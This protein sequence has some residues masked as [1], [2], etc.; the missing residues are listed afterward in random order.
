MISQMAPAI[1]WASF[2]CFFR[3][4]CTSDVVREM[5]IAAI[6]KTPSHNRIFQKSLNSSP[7]RV[8]I[9]VP[10]T[11]AKNV[12]KANPVATGNR[13]NALEI[14]LGYFL[15]ASNICLKY[16]ICSRALQKKDVII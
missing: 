5:S 13:L 4:S 6:G 7:N 15:K 8:V 2:L 12:K 1:S 14:W 9:S 10:A 11:S 16:K 3:D